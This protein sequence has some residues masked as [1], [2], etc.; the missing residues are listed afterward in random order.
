MGVDFRQV[1]V[2]ELSKFHA[3]STSLALKQQHTVR[4]KVTAR[5]AADLL[6]SGAP[7]QRKST[8]ML[9][10]RVGSP[11]LCRFCARYG[12]PAARCRATE[13]QCLQ[14]A[15]THPDPTTYCKSAAKRCPQCASGRAAWDCSCQALKAWFRAQR[16]EQSY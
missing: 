3:G 7:T 10:G 15:E 14:R 16:A 13:S 12:H 9:K 2:L 1:E 4:V 8:H 6:C 5:E 11:Q